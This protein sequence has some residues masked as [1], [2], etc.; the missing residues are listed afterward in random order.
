M[1]SLEQIHFNCLN[2]FNFPKQQRQKS[3]TKIF[4]RKQPRRCSQ[5]V[6][7]WRCFIRFG[8]VIHWHIEPINFR[9]HFGN[10]VKSNSQ[11]KRGCYA[12]CLPWFGTFSICIRKLSNWWKIKRY[13]KQQYFCHGRSLCLSLGTYF[14]WY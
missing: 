1:H 14:R 10:N 3:F 2:W 11:S 5:S 6:F 9:L 12:R 13:P 7:K 4:T 8:F